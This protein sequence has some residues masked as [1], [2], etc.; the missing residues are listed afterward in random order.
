VA[1]I[2]SGGHLPAGPF[3]SRL[4]VAVARGEMLRGLLSESGALLS[5]KAAASSCLMSFIFPETFCFRSALGSLHQKES[6][7]LMKA[8]LMRW[9]NF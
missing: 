1:G 9:Y 2:I 7:L 3:I 6:G 5:F 4:I 8:I